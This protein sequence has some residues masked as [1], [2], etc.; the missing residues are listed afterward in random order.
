MPAEIEDRYTLSQFKPFRKTTVTANCIHPLVLAGA[1]RPQQARK[2][3][4]THLWTMGTRHH[5]LALCRG[6]Y[7]IVRRYATYGSLKPRATMIRLRALWQGRM[8]G[9]DEMWMSCEY[10]R[11][12]PC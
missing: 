2:G 8:E 12:C 10:R 5:W 9:I 11:P 3:V 6:T 4:A 1:T 7:S